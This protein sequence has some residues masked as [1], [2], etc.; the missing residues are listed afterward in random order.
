MLWL[1]AYVNREWWAYDPDDGQLIRHDGEEHKHIAYVSS[2]L[3]D[4]SEAVHEYLEDEEEDENEEELHVDTTEGET[5]EED[6]ED[7]DEEDEEYDDDEDD[8]DDEDIEYEEW[9][10]YK[11]RL[12]RTDNDDGVC[13]GLSL[14]WCIERLKTN[15]S[16]EQSLPDYDVARE[17]QEL[18]ERIS[19][20]FEE[21]LDELLED[22][23][24]YANVQEF[25]GPYS[26]ENAMEFLFEDSGTFI[27]A[28]RSVSSRVGHA[29]AVYRDE[30]EIGFFDANH[31]VFRFPSERELT[32][33]FK[34]HMQRIFR[35]HVQEFDVE[36]A[37]I[38]D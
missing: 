21:Q 10:P 24:A 29:V 5:G 11:Y 32:R 18:Y 38:W 20:D 14:Y 9:D 26:L 19:A 35:H 33:V 37:K 6:E 17:T 4:A 7:E 15:L 12:F 31:G 3:T 16:L 13:L 8:E 2:N 30:E 22:E 28:A 34:Y 25:E 1:S 23:P 27:V 36:I